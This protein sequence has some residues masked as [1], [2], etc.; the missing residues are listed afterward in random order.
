[1]I[2]GKSFYYWLNIFH[3]CYEWHTDGGEAAARGKK[4]KVVK[5]GYYTRVALPDAGTVM[6][7]DNLTMQ[8]LATMRDQYHEAQWRKFKK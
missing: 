3:L 2:A 4:G 6:D 5:T 7:Q 8:V 1:M